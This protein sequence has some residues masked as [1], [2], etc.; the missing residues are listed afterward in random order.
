VLDVGQS[1]AEP[2]AYVPKNKIPVKKTKKNPI[3]LSFQSH[4]RRRLLY[5]TALETA[6]FTL[7]L[8][9]KRGRVKRHP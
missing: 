9:T 2:R 6:R 1:T 3:A 5:E 8:S 4:Q 7:L